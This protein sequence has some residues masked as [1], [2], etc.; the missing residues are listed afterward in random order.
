MTLIDAAKPLSVHNPG[1]KISLKAPKGTWSRHLCVDNKDA[2]LIGGS[3]DT[4]EFVFERMEGSNKNISPSYIGDFLRGGP[5][6]VS[7]DVLETC[8]TVLPSGTYMCC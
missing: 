7:E 3:C 5:T 6:H 2:Y 8:S 4:C 1:S